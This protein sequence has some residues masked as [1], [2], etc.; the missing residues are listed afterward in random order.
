MLRYVSVGAEGVR[1][2]AASTSAADARGA[3]EYAADRTRVSA[4]PASEVALTVS[5]RPFGT[6]TLYTSRGSSERSTVPAMR[7]EV[8]FL[9]RSAGTLW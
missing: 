7:V 8:V 2:P 6:H 3:T 5:L 1:V 4:A 9:R